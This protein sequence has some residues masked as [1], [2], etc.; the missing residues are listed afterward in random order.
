MDGTRV[1]HGRDAQRSKRC[2][3]AGRHHLG[4]YLPSRP[5]PLALSN[6]SRAEIFS[7][8]DTP[9]AK[10]GNQQVVRAVMQKRTLSRPERCPLELFEV[11]RECWRFEAS[12]RPS[13][14]QLLPM[15]TAIQS[16]MR[17]RDAEVPVGSQTQLEEPVRPSTTA[18]TLASE[19]ALTQLRETLALTLDEAEIQL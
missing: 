1:Y 19:Q 11:L 6:L 2:M 5:N 17:A 9:W 10:L 16:G 12:A 18:S 4:Y 15:L 13:A 14:A 8:G 3:D 7:A